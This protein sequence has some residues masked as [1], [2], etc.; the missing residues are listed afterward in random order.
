MAK[1]NNAAP[2][3]LRQAF[4]DFDMDKN[5]TVSFEELKQAVAALGMTAEEDS[6]R[7]MF[8]LADTND[9]GQLS[10]EEYLGLFGKQP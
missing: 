10:F 2:A 6:L 8:N 9:D 3:E 1:L 4:D 7:S 5:G